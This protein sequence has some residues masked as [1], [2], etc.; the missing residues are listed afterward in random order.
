MVDYNKLLIGIGFFC[1]ITSVFIVL[2]GEP[3]Y[4]N[5][6]VEVDKSTHTT[7]NNTIVKTEIVKETVV[8]EQKFNPTSQ[9]VS[10][11]QPNAT[12]YIWEC[13]DLKK[14]VALND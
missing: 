2:T 1:L 10:I 5:I 13:N 9:C 14:E 12:K 8:K 4:K 6:T 11:R 7:L 3:K